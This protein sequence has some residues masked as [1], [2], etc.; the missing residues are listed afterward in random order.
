MEPD[1][2][3]KEEKKVVLLKE[4]I[5]FYLSNFEK[6][7]TENRGFSVGGAVSFYTQLIRSSFIGYLMMML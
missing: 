2:F 6:V 1:Q 7:I 3:K 5:P 4:K